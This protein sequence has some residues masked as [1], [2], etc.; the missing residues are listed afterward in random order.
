[1]NH[2]LPCGHVPCICENALR[3]TSHACLMP[4]EAPHAASPPLLAQHFAYT[5][6]ASCLSHR[7]ASPSTMTHH[8][9]SHLLHHH[10][11]GTTIHDHPYPAPQ[12]FA[13][14]VMRLTEDMLSPPLPLAAVV[15]SPSLTTPNI[16]MGD[17]LNSCYMD[18]GDGFGEPQSAEE[19]CALQLASALRETMKITSTSPDTYLAQVGGWG[20]DCSGRRGC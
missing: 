16:A 13:C 9:A 4:S 5:Q 2:S 6:H 14:K 17:M 15:A 10:D 8:H 7:H 19:G 1:M 12:C 18:S 11:R 3:L 20:P